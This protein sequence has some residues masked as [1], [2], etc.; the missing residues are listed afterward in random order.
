MVVKLNPTMQIF[1]E[2]TKILDLNLSIHWWHW[3]MLGGW[4]LLLILIDI[5]VLHR[6]DEAT[7]IRDA[8]WQSI[9]WILLGIG[10]GV[11]ILNAFGGEA[12]TQYFS[13]Y[14]VEKS[15]SID[16]VFTWSLVLTYFRIPK[17]YQHRVLFWGVLGAIILRA[18]FVFAG[19][20]LI[21]R[22]EPVLIIFGLILIWSGIKI[23]RT[24][25][26]HE[27]DPHNSRFFRIAKSII[28]VSRKLDGHKLFTHENGKLV[29]TMLF[30]ALLVVEFTDVVFAVDSVPAVLAV[31]HEPFIIIASNAAAILGM[32]ALYFVFDHIKENFWMLNYC[33]ALLLL[34]VG[35]KLSIAPHQVFGV[36]WLNIHIPT[37][38]S[39]MIIGGLLVAGVL[40]SQFIPQ[41]QSSKTREE[42]V[43]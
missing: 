8:V 7:K 5:L 27:Y 16:N 34:F 37:N 9:A 29:A 14:L 23:F 13:G 24:K 41:P 33:L 21:E 31:S 4:F 6:K 1:A 22:F 43:K 20:A 39:L 18:I 36:E 32:R 10:L 30:M 17:K 2:V 28:P 12:A 11:V 19:I 38:L 42:L 3:A 15:L 40:G 26:E 25:K 35:I